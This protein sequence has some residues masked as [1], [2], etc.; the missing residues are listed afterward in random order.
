MLPT[1][2]AWMQALPSVSL[3][4]SSQLDSGISNVSSRTEGDEGD[5]T[6]KHMSFSSATCQNILLIKYPF[7]FF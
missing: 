6:S 3:S 1:G 5:K 7:I 4:S 2:P